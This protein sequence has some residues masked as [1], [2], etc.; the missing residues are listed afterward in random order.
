MTIAVVGIG[1]VLMGD[2]GVGVHAIHALREGFADSDDVLLID[3]GTMSLDLLPFI[4]KADKLLII[5]AVNA[6]KRPG[7][8]VCIEGTEVP[9][10]LSEKL[11]VHQIGVPDLLFS[12]GFLG[13]LPR[14]LCLIGVQPGNLVVDISLSAELN[15]AMGPLVRT[16]VEKLR[17]WGG[18]LA[19]RT[20]PVSAAAVA[21]CAPKMQ[22]VL[23]PLD[24]S[25]PLNSAF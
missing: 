2:D 18:S 5:D 16:V 3:G 21:G 4:E 1:N 14:D 8:I 22:N 9:V 10:Y 23:Y 15:A 20:A 17:S 24:R 11:S 7:V 6:G 12:A 19:R 13:M 25:W